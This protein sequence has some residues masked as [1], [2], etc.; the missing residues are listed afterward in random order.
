MNHDQDLLDSIITGQPREITPAAPK[1]EAT[2]PDVFGLRGLLN[3]PKPKPAWW[4]RTKDPANQPYVNMPWHGVFHEAFQNLPENSGNVFMDS[5]KGLYEIGAGIAMAGYN[6]QLGKGFSNIKKETEEK[7]PALSGLIGIVGGGA[8]KASHLDYVLR[9]MREVSKDDFTSE[10]LAQGLREPVVRT[11][12]F[13]M[14]VEIYKQNWG[15]GDD[16]I[17]GLKRYIAENPADFLADI[18]TVTTLGAGAVG[19]A[20]KAGR[21]A[22]NTRLLSRLNFNRFYNQH[23][24]KFTRKT[25]WSRGLRRSA[26]QVQD[27]YENLSTNLDKFSAQARYIGTG[28]I[29]GNYPPGFWANMAHYLL[30]YIDV[31]AVPALPLKI[32][33]MLGV[34]DELIKGK[35]PARIERNDANI[36]DAVGV[37][38]LSHIEPDDPRILELAEQLFQK[39]HPD[40]FDNPRKTTYTLEEANKVFPGVLGYDTRFATAPIEYLEIKPDEYKAFVYTGDNPANVDTLLNQLDELREAHREMLVRHFIEKRGLSSYPGEAT[41]AFT[42]LQKRYANIYQE[43]RANDFVPL[44]TLSDDQLTQFNIQRIE[45][46]NAVD[47]F[48]RNVVPQGTLP[49][50]DTPNPAIVRMQQLKTATQATGKK[51]LDLTAGKTDNASDLILN[52]VNNV[53]GDT[54]FDFTKKYPFEMETIPITIGFPQTLK[55]LD[56]LTDTETYFPHEQIKKF[57]TALDEE[58]HKFNDID[59]QAYAVFLKSLRDRNSITYDDIHSLLHERALQIKDI[60]SSQNNYTLNTLFQIRDEILLNGRSKGITN[61]PQFAQ[62]MNALTLDI[63]ANLA[64]Y[65]QWGRSRFDFELLDITKSIVESENLPSRV[66]YSTVRNLPFNLPHARFSTIM[67]GVQNDAKTILQLI[68]DPDQDLYKVWE[69]HFF[70]PYNE[71]TLNKWVTPEEIDKTANE[72]FKTLS[73]NSRYYHADAAT[74]NELRHTIDQEA[75]KLKIRLNS[76]Q[77]ILDQF[78]QDVQEYREGFLDAVSTVNNN[79]VRFFIQELNQKKPQLKPQFVHDILMD[80]NTDLDAIL[81]LLDEPSRNKLSNVALQYIFDKELKQ[82]NMNIASS[83]DRFWRVMNVNELHQ[84]FFHHAGEDIE[85][86]RTLTNL[87]LALDESLA[88]QKRAEHMDYFRSDLNTWRNLGYIDRHTSLANLETEFV[89]LAAK[90]DYQAIA[91]HLQPKGT[92]TIEIVPNVEYEG[93]NRIQV[94][95]KGKYSVGNQDAAES[96]VSGGNYVSKDDPKGRNVENR[97]VMVEFAGD[98][99]GAIGSSDWSSFFIVPR[100]MEELHRNKPEKLRE[101]QM[102]DNDFFSGIDIET[103]REMDVPTAYDDPAREIIAQPTAI[104]G[105][106]D[107]NEWYQEAKSGE[108]GNIIWEPHT[109]NLDMVDRVKYEKIFGSQVTD[110]LY[111]YQEFMK[112]YP[113]FARGNY[114]AA[115]EFTQRAAKSGTRE[116]RAINNMQGIFP[117]IGDGDADI[118]RLELIFKTIGETNAEQVLGTPGI[119]ELLLQTVPKNKRPKIRRWIA[120]TRRAVHRSQKTQEHEEQQSQPKLLPYTGRQSAIERLGGQLLVH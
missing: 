26:D 89:K 19:A 34:A 46:K 64:A 36:I 42:G 88:P 78:A 44:E 38:T 72:T 1:K 22:L 86:G 92:S 14:M 68:Q 53:A 95:R 74:L 117:L 120:E 28:D 9:L 108:Y 84:N 114:D 99:V 115:I 15:L 37:G 39:T 51:I 49:Y 67:D 48:L 98:D 103:I 79:F 56:N 93:H 119:T 66:F 87:E 101:L 94:I 63:F 58:K 60:E 27:F 7:Y 17:V 111:K 18:S 23:I 33:A 97:Y 96:I 109:L 71:G 90:K 75:K 57:Q 31:G 70:L 110:L 77:K 65:P 10:T 55:V 61:Q 81:N 3:P 118:G 102:S 76:H 91:D 107:I 2:P 12:L 8:Y 62:V 24:D 105:V 116:N 82:H 73:G 16:G 6:Y 41:A 30:T 32:P 104:M 83:G 69:E 45:P 20:A 80:K 11:A 106:Y 112:E 21:L 25:R 100:L 40:T 47:A 4:Q 113:V 59:E 43:M 52:F 13:D 50:T 54:F 85:M 5:M 35:N 29:H